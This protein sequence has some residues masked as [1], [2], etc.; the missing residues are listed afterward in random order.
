MKYIQSFVLTAAMT[1]PL[2]A[3]ASEWT[4]TQPITVLQFDGSNEDAYFAGGA[5]WGSSSCPNATYA[6]VAASLSGYKQ[7]LT[8]G[9]SAKMAATPVR[10]FGVCGSN[11]YFEA[12]YISLE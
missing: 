6:R 3:F 11:G 7:L 1:L 2:Q 5:K 8:I 9:L 12:T 10:L 4:I